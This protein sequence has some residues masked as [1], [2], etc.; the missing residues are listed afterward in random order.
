MPGRALAFV[1]AGLFFLIGGCEDKK[2]DPYSGLS[3]MV[4][5]RNEARRLIKEDN[6]SKKTGVRVNKKDPPAV[7]QPVKKQG[8]MSAA[9]IYERPV[10]ITDSESGLEI[11]KGVAYL[12]KEGKIV[13]IKLV[14][15]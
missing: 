5:E 15:E 14:E 11:A 10:E 3:N 9:I 1:I 2:E 6:L 13:R 4:A 12:N 8:D 7:D